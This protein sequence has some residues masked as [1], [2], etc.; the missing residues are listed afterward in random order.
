MLAHLSATAKVPFQAAARQDLAARVRAAF[1][2]AARRSA[3]DRRR[4]AL[5]AWRERAFRE[6]A[7]RPSRF[8]FCSIAR[9]RRGDVFRCRAPAR[10]AAA[11]LRFVEAFALRGGGGS[12]TPDRLAF[13][14]PIAIAC[15]VD[16]APCL[17]SRM[18]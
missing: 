9:D 17:P 8:S 6:A 12:F 16:R 3:G 1:R 5:F 7:L 15:F 2:A 14:S 10:L 18:W 13:D 11:A 4:A